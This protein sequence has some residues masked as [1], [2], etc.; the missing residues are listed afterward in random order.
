MHFDED[1]KVLFVIGM[2]NELERLLQQE[3]DLQPENM[4]IL[5]SF[6][7]VILQPYSDLMRDIILVVYE[8]NTEEI[9]IVGIDSPGKDLVNAKNIIEKMTEREGNAEIIRALD[10]LFENCIPEFPGG[11]INEWLEGSRT[12]AEGIQSSVNII[13]HHPLIP[14]YV[15][16]RGL[17]LNK[18]NGKL[19][20]MNNKRLIY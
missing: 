4:L 17:L 11:S 8:E 14:S 13:R 12:V 18:E 20:E 1:K 3:T 16:V 10:Y 15:K 6:G 9:F 5:R 2:E 19:T 7:P